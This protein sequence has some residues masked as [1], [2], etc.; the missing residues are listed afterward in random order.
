MKNLAIKKIEGSPFHQH[1]SFAKKLQNQSVISDMMRKTLLYEKVARK[2]L[3]KLTPGGL[4]I[5]EI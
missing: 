1:Y 2:M 5:E 3:I 4:P